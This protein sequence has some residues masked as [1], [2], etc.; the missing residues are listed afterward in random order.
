MWTTGAIGERPE[1]MTVDRL[2][3]RGHEVAILTAGFMLDEQMIDEGT[4]A[5]LLRV[6]QMMFERIFFDG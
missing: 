3:Q 4:V 5:D 2:R 6:H 1:I